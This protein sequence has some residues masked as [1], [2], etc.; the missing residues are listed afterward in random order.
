MKNPL[1]PWQRTAANAYDADFSHVETLDDCRDVGDS[2]F[3]GIM[4]ELSPSE[5]CDTL[6]EAI[7]RARV[8]AEQA[9]AVVARL[10][11]ES[12]LQTIE[13]RR[14]VR[15]SV[16]VPMLAGETAEEAQMRVIASQDALTWEAYDCEYWRDRDAVQ[17]A[18][19]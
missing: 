12:P 5:G 17:K 16:V 1:S 15:E 13:I 10:E 7:R 4:V 9:A 8:I 19:Q 6:A 3:S 11:K 14:I 2:I 18:F